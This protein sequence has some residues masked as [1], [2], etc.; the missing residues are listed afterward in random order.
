GFYAWDPSDG[1]YLVGIKAIDNAR[2]YNQDQMPESMKEH[3]ARNNYYMLPFLFGLLGL[4]FHLSKR[5]NE[6]L[7]LLALF[8]ITGI[9]III[10]S[11]QPPNEPRERDYVLVG[12]FF[13]YCI[14]IGMA[15]LALFEIFRE[16]LNFGG[17]GGAIAAVALVAIA[18]L[19][20]G[21]ENF[22]DHSRRH[23]SGARDYANNFLESC[24]DNAIIFTYGDNDTYPLWYAQEVEGIRTDVRVVNLSLISVDWYI[25]QLRRKVNN[26]PKIKMTIPREEYRG[27]KRNQVFYPGQG[28]E[29]PTDLRN[30]IRFIGESHPLPLQ[31][32]KQTES[33][34][35]TRKVFLPVDRR[36]I[37]E[38]KV[39]DL[40]D[41][42]IRVPDRL[43]F[44]IPKNALIKGDLAVLDIV[45]SN[46]WDRPIYFAV[47]CRKESLLG[48]DDFLQLEGL[49][50]KLVPTKTKSDGRFGIIGS[51]RVASDIVYDNLMN[52]FRW[53]NFDKKDLFVDRSYGPS[54]QSHHAVI[55]RTSEDLIRRGKQD[56]AV[57]LMEKYFEVFPS[58]NFTYDYRTFQMLAL[59]I[60]A[61]GYDKA[62]PHI[63]ELA[64]E[65]AD[66]LEFFYSLDP[67][68]L[69]AG[70]AQDFSLYNRAKDDMLRVLAQQGDTAFE[71]EI[72]AL[73][74][75]YNVD[76]L[77]N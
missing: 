43:D 28:Q 74:E 11:N 68:D 72:K 51:G 10:Y 73:L 6:F 4:L 58:M 34:M 16:R 64:L 39:I 47:T 60:Q 15:V 1:N 52:R 55:L 46:M 14:W 45:A 31:G 36:K 53:G 61:G 30:L 66:H 27:K 41:S 13:T 38:N 32:G 24:E 5:P 49:A 65:T 23:H 62:K 17:N 8:I 26:S 70:F 42:T 3:K 57:A 76:R 75:P 9:G 25:D 33:Y 59:M 48:M 35:P 44:T 29:N 71:D 7:G 56:K 12:S 21:F 50:L 54:V 37:A 18:P 19:L 40:Q 20:M 22:D 77:K 69:E 2:L 67:E 63:K